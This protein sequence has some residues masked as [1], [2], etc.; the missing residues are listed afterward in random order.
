MKHVFWMVFLFAVTTAHA[1]DHPKITQLLA[2]DT[3]PPGVVFDIVTGDA[4]GLNW[5][6]P[7]IA[8]YAKRLRAKFPKLNIA[9]VTYGQEMFALQKNLQSVTPN[10]HAEIEQ[11]VKEQHIPVY[12]S[13]ID[14]SWRKIP[15]DAF[16]QY[17]DVAP[18]GPDQVKHYT[19][20]GYIQVRISS[21]VNGL[22]A[23]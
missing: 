18:T 12:I 17:I 7:E 20:L 15:P 4:Q 5:A 10:V 13:S 16:P 1:F 23:Q 22:P 19:D 11:L 8:D 14:A 2:Q 3:S 21:A 9:V 6:I